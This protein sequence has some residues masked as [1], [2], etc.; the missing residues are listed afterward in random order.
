MSY[1]A[2]QDVR[3]PQPCKPRRT[4][5]IV[6]LVA[7]FFGALIMGIVLGSASTADGSNAECGALA[8][9]YA[10]L[11]SEGIDAGLSGDEQRMLDVAARRDALGEDVKNIC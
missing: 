5:W 8:S 10:G 6:S 7:C 9:E 3:L 11:V 2:A 1:Y 4:P